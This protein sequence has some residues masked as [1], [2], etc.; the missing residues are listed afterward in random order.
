MKKPVS[1]PRRGDQPLAAA[2]SAPKSKEDKALLEEI[3]ALGGDEQDF[4]LLADLDSASE[5]EAAESSALPIDD[6]AL[7]ALASDIKQF[8]KSNALKAEPVPDIEASSTSASSEDEAAPEPAVSSVKTI[9]QSLEKGK[10]KALPEPAPVAT[11]NSGWLVDPNPS[12]HTLELDALPAPS[13][14]NGHTDSADVKQALQARSEVLLVEASQQYSDALLPDS[15]A[16]NHY[17]KTAKSTLRTARQIPLSNSDKAFVSSI[18]ESGTSADRLSALLLL[19]QSSPM[20]CTRYLQ[21]I[22]AQCRKKSRSEAAKATRLVIEWCTKASPSCLLPTDRKLRLFVDQPGLTAL[23]ALSHDKTAG[24]HQRKLIEQY[25]LLW[26]FEDWLK[27]WFFEL[28]QVAESFSSDPLPFVRGQALAHFA[29][30]LAATPEQ[31]QN[32]LRL[33]VNKLGDNDRAIASKTSHLIL[34]TLQTHPMM[35]AVVVRE[36]AEI[37][38]RPMPQSAKDKGPQRGG[39]HRRY[40]GMI[41][42]NQIMHTRNEQ[43]QQVADKVLEVCFDVFHELVGDTAEEAALP[44]KKD[45]KRKKGRKTSNVRPAEDTDGKMMAAVLTGVNRAFPYASS[46]M[47]MLQSRLDLLF[48]ICHSGNVNVS[49]QAMS[50]LNQ[51]AKRNET[52]SDRYYKTIYNSLLDPRLVNTTKHAMYLNLLFKAMKADAVPARVQAFVKR[53]VQVL[54]LH[55]PP[56]VCGALYLLA[57]LMQ[58]TPSLRSML[59]VPEDADAIIEA[60]N[61]GEEGAPQTGYDGTKREPRYARAQSSCLWDILYLTKH[62]HPAVA[63][64]ASSVLEGEEVQISGELES[65]TIVHFLDQLAYRAPKQISKAKGASV[66]QPAS[67]DRDGLSVSNRK[68]LGQNATVNSASFVRQKADDV[69]AQERFLHTYFRQRGVK[70]KQAD[71]AASEAGSLGSVS[72]FEEDLSDVDLDEVPNLDLSE[73]DAQ[74]E[75]GQEGGEESELDE[76]EVWAAM[77]ATM[78]PLDEQSSDAG[79]AST[80]MID[81]SDVDSKALKGDDALR[82]DSDFDDELVLSEDALESSEEE[83]DLVRDDGEESDEEGAALLEDEEDAVLSSEEE[84]AAPEEPAR[85]RKKRKADVPTFADASAYAHLLGQDEKEDE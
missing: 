84:E 48:R 77:Q 58:V 61:E 5:D 31:E 34:Q 4:A 68:G 20:H 45:K 35:K 74:S 18:L 28:L 11:A 46:D 66:M 81:T 54:S 1:A 79:E 73:S 10:G 44:D 57:K 69:P 50:L 26:A 22:L 59:T 55:Q 8:L 25:L 17:G 67:A 37:V 30:L 2:S 36:V 43:G 40:Y 32:L 70:N 85:K 60:V 19:A 47:T 6:K 33:L 65:Y 16:S 3:V 82:I 63:Q 71:E 14:S 21:Q 78:P 49:V 38:L 7:K 72:S 62:Y 39:Q 27:K 80:S 23:I 52:I 24:K 83:N 51:I 53:L 41:T 9:K 29:A 15:S 56:F 12:W 76:E 64:I 42:L 13:T 75:E